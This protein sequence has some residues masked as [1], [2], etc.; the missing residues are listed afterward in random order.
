[1]HLQLINLEIIYDF[2][3]QSE[4]L[5]I[6]TRLSASMSSSIKTKGCF[7]FVLYDAKFLRSKEKIN[8][9]SDQPYPNPT[10]TLTQPWFGQKQI[11]RVKP[12]PSP[13]PTLPQTNPTLVWSEAKH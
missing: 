4:S 2:V 7:L 3:I 9:I 12:Y 11:V 8:S 1:M 10:P 6:K 5:R 13:N